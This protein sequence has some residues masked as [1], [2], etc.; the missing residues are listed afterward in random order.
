[1]FANKGTK[2]AQELAPQSNIS[3]FANWSNGSKWLRRKQW[4]TCK[5][6]QFSPVAKTIAGKNYARLQFQG[7]ARLSLT[8]AGRNICIILENGINFDNFAAFAKL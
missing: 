8:Q 1:M 3:S 4:A 5:L 6:F 2:L 7:T